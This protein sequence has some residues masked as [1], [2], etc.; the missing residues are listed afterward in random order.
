MLDAEAL[1]H[2]DQIPV[3]GVELPNA[4]FILPVALDA[5]LMAARDLVLVIF[6]VFR[7][8]FGRVLVE[9]ADRALVAC[10]RGLGLGLR[11]R[12]RDEGSVGVRTVVEFGG[13]R[14]Y[15]SF[16]VWHCE[17]TIETALYPGCGEI[18]R[19]FFLVSGFAADK[20]SNSGRRKS[21]GFLFHDPACFQCLPDQRCGGYPRKRVCFGSMP[22]HM[23]MF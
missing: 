15:G 21:I 5:D 20:P 1:D 18:V 6:K 12:R 8:F 19:K 14:V 3:L 13:D 7:H 2:A 16:W 11:P 10:A 9:E 23:G 17:G 4:L 22:V